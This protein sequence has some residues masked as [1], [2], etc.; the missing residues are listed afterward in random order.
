MWRGR[1]GLA[2]THHWMGKKHESSRQFT[3]LTNLKL[4]L[5]RRNFSA[6]QILSDSKRLAFAGLRAP[7]LTSRSTRQ[8]DP[9]V[10]VSTQKNRKFNRKGRAFI[11]RVIFERCKWGM[12]IA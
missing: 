2:R 11:E 4:A 5:G 6:H 9:S 1:G 3:P 12:I 8:I 10:D 7:S